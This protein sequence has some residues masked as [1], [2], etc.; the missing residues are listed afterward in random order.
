MIECCCGHNILKVGDFFLRVRWNWQLWWLMIHVFFFLNNNSCLG[1]CDLSIREPFFVLVYIFNQKKHI[2]WTKI[3]LKSEVNA[4]FAFKHRFH[5]QN[6]KVSEMDFHSF[7]VKTK[8]FKIK[9]FRLKIIV[10]IELSFSFNSTRENLKK[11]S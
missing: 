4:E 1:I 3:R 10:G 8:K 6:M 5:G 7:E 9:R 2:W 11:Q